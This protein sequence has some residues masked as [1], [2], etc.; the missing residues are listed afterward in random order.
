MGGGEGSLTLLRS[1]GG[2]NLNSVQD[3]FDGIRES[4][5]FKRNVEQLGHWQRTWQEKPKD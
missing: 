2:V 4:P 5:Q 3:Y 1:I